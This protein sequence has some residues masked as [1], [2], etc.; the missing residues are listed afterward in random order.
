M[1]IHNSSCWRI[2]RDGEPG[3]WREPPTFSASG[4]SGND[5]GHRAEIADFI[6]AIQEGRSTRSNIFESYKTM[7]LYEAIKESAASGRVVPVRPET[8]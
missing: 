5:T 2:T 8:V 6:A 1:S 3:E 7:V 4:D